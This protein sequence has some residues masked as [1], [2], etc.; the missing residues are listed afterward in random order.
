L[1]ALE[2]AAKAEEIGLAKN[3]IILSCKISNVQEL[4]AIYQDCPAVVIMHCIWVLPKLA[5]LQGYSF[6]SRRLISIMQ[7][8]IGDTIRIL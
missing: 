2:S 5:W 1:S 7:Q 4:I 8:G 6:L 3:K